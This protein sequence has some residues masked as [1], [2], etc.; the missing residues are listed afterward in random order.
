M[1]PLTT[2]RIMK[3]LI[4]NQLSRSFISS[5]G[6]RCEADGADRFEVAIDL[7]MGARK[8]ACAACTLAEKG[9]SGM[10]TAGAMG[11]GID[12]ADVI[13]ALRDPHWRRGMVN[14]MRG[15]GTFGVQRPFVPGA[16]F[17]VVWDVTY[18]CNL[19]CRHCYA[20]AG[21]PHPDELSTDDA[22]R[23]IDK[24]SDWGVPIIAFSGGEPL[25]RSDIL[26]LAHHAHEKGI[27]VAMATNGTL[28]SEH[29][30]KEMAEAGVRYLQISLDGADAA[31]H[32][33]FRG[34]EGAFD[35]TVAG[36]RNAVNEGFFTSISITA[37]RANLAAVPDVIDLGTRMGVN[38]IMVYNFVPAGRGRDL[39]DI[40]LDPA[41]REELLR[42][43]YRRNNGSKTQVLTTAPQFARV[44]L[45]SC[46][47]GSFLVPT[48]FY[49]LNVDDKLLNLTEFIGGC[50]AGR[51][52]VAVR[53]NGDIDPC[54]FFP[55]S[56]GNALTDDLGTLWANDKLIRD[57]RDKDLLKGNCGQCEYRYHCGGCRA[58][59]YGYFDDPLAPD[60][61]C[62][63]NA[64]VHRSML[65]DKIG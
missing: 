46:R 4:G 25:V 32:D 29:K 20:S 52:Y 15:I 27:Y 37:T 8:E 5:L 12:R 21:S 55:H 59:A 54:V 41:E 50:G 61:G 42:L 17:Q 24:L 6:R 63:K 39:L 40:D 14:V 13:E 16:P 45:Q 35:R 28:I 34:I 60:P 19:R 47:G 38:W 51:F 2:V 10:L 44:A 11:F 22:H 64:E 56:I 62:I 18:G 7:M 65:I 26:D 3:A 23:V 9:L 33:S 43:L 36:I 49:N 48:H 31:T 57:L 30:A 53:A 1:K 58:R